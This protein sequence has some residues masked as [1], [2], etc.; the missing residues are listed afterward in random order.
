MIAKRGRRLG[1]RARGGGWRRVMSF[2]LAV[3]MSVMGLSPATAM[4]AD[5][6]VTSDPQYYLDNPVLADSV[7]IPGG[8]NA[9]YDSWPTRN[10]STLYVRGHDTGIFMYCLQQP[11]EGRQG[12]GT[13]VN[14]E[15]TQTYDMS[16]N[17][18]TWKLSFAPRKGTWT[19]DAMLNAALGNKFFAEKEYAGNV[20]KIQQ[21]TQRLIWVLGNTGGRL[22]RNY[23]LAYCG[24]RTNS[25]IT[26]GDESDAFWNRLTT[27]IRQNKKNYVARGIRLAKTDGGQ[28]VGTFWVVPKNGKLSVRK[29]SADPGVTDGNPCY[30]LSTAVYKAYGS[31]ANAKADRGAIATFKVKA[32]GTTD[33][34]D[35]SASKLADGKTVYVRETAAGRNYRLDSTVHSVTLKPGKTVTLNVKDEPGTDPNWAMVQKVDAD[36]NEVSADLA[37][38][39]QGGSTLKGAQFT[40]RYYANTD[41]ITSGAPTRTWV[42][43]TGENGMVRFDKSDPVSGDAT[44]KNSKGAVVLPLGTFTVQ[45]TR[46]PQGYSLTDG[47]FHTFVESMKADGTIVR[48][49]LD[50]W[51]QKNADKDVEGRAVAD[52]VLT[53][54]FRMGKVDLETSQGKALAAAEIGGAQYSVTN[55]NANPVKVGGKY[56]ASGSVVATYTAGADGVFESGELPYGTYEVREVRAPK[57]YTVNSSWVGRVTISGKGGVVDGGAAPDQVIRGDLALTK[58][59]EDGKSTM[60]GVAWLVTSKATGE[61]HVVMTDAS[62]RLDTSASHAKHSYKTNANDAAVTVAADGSVTVDES[63]LDPTAGVWFTGSKDAKWSAD[64]NTYTIDGHTAKPNDSLGAL[65][66]DTYT[67]RELRTS[68]TVGHDL[69][70]QAVTVQSVGT[71][72][73]G[74]VKDSDF[75]IQTSATDSQTGTHTGVTTVKDTITDVVTY[76]GLKVGTEYTLVA[77]PHLVNADGTDGGALKDASGKAYSTSV[78]FTPKQAT[79]TVKVSLDIDSGGLAGRKIVMFE[80]CK[81]GKDTVAVHQDIKDSDQTVSYPA[82]GTTASNAEGDKVVPASDQCEVT[83]TISYKGL[84]PGEAYTVTGTLHYVGDNGTDG[85]AVKGAD[86]KAVTASTTIQPTAA[87]G[88][89]TVSFKFDASSMQGKKVVAFETLTQAGADKKQVTITKHENAGDTAQTVSFPSVHTNATDKETG[90]HEALGSETVTVTDEVSYDGLVPGKEYTVTGTLHVKADDGFDAGTLLSDGSVS[91][92]GKATGDAAPVTATSTFTPNA[93][94]GKVTLTFSFPRTKLQ[95]KSVVAFETVSRNGVTYATHADITDADQTVNVPSVHTTATGKDTGTHETLG[96][97]STTVKDEV[98][99]TNLT[100]GKEYT[101]TGALHVKG[102][103]DKGNVTDL[104]ILLKDGRAYDPKTGKVSDLTTTSTGNGTAAGLFSAGTLKRLAADLDKSGSEKLTFTYVGSKYE[105]TKKDGTYTVSQGDSLTL[106]FDK[107]GNAKD[108]KIQE[109]TS[110]SSWMLGQEVDGKWVVTAPDGTKKTYASEEEYENEVAKAGL[111]SMIV[112]YDANGKQ[113]DSFDV[114]STPSESDSNAAQTESVKLDKDGLPTDAVKATKTFKP[115]KANGSVTLEFGFDGSKL[116]GRSV[117][118]FENVSRD[119]KTVAT[120]ADITDADQTVNV[121]KIGT[122]ATGE[123]GDKQVTCGKTSVTDTVSYSN[124]IPGHT[125]TVTGHLVDANGKAVSDEASTT[126][127]AKENYGSAQ[128]KISVD[129]SSLGGTKIVAFETLRDEGKHVVAQHEDVNDADQAVTVEK[130]STPVTPSTPSN[131][132]TNMPQ[133]GG[134][135]IWIVL[136]AAGAAIAVGYAYNRRHAAGADAPEDENPTE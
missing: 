21:E 86:G 112:A 95:G 71:I 67:V 57:G 98:K 28:D 108:L 109:S 110:S 116:L 4:A 63:K 123:N 32:D 91:A 101:V 13:V 80:D 9:C 38:D 17:T 102:T 133:L 60:G 51:D 40:V 122:V 59:A 23:W 55:A 1:A 34:Q 89:A 96:T 42:Y 16:L 70:T 5:V 24:G 73:W 128:V 72:D 7:V 82:I 18:S 119:G 90:T 27:Y 129:T 135:A 11:K 132:T 45:E 83:D 117:V 136:V 49:N 74:T 3:A 48:K 115:E 88:T 105:L 92:D 44:Y 127:T 50:N 87:D 99:Y 47:S 131:P 31:E 130:P 97:E 106:T 53:G 113:V 25:G 104:G 75:H 6:K 29:S 120:H 54:R 78:K 26:G 8:G 58:T 69:V 15:G 66:Y 77:T 12:P 65:P 126:F 124:L 22:D 39:A 37:R 64:G 46:A 14:I 10:G 43:E 68:A 33:A 19:Q 125:Y 41:G 100:P 20:K 81:E 84:V 103:D 134:S 111:A 30:D 114:S 94:N 85:G 2:V 56:Y 93:A 121:P 118:A 107:N 61:S 36:G 62:G 35:V 76:S 52:Q 79:G